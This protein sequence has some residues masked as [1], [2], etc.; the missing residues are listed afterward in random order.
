[1]KPWILGISGSHNGA[2]CL[3]RGN[4]I[5]VA[6]QEERLVGVKRARVHG[7]R[8]GLGIRYC[9]DT[10]GISA[11][12][13]SM[14]VIS[15]Q[16][17]ATAEENDLWL[18]PAFRGL[19]GVPRRSVSHHLA[20]AASAL[21]TSGYERA[22][23]LVIDGLGSPA[24]DLT[25]AARRV[26]LGPRDDG[27]EHLSL[28]HAT[29]NDITPIE[30]HTVAGARWVEKHPRGMWGFATL[31]GMFSAASQQIFGNP[32]DAGKVMGLAPYGEPAIPMDEILRLDGERLLFPNL[33]QRRFPF[34]ERWPAHEREYR[35]LAASVQAALEVAVLAIARRLREK[36]GER[37]LCYAGG[38]ALNSVVNERLCRETGF[39]RVYVIPAA[40]DSG[41][42]IGAAYLGLWEL[43]GA[44]PGV[45]MQ[46]DAP[47]RT[48][49]ASEIEAA[50]RATPD[51]AAERPADLLG[52]VVARLSRGEIGGWFQGGSELGPRALGQRSIVCSPAGESTKE[53]LNARVKFREMFRPFAPAVL[54]ERATEWF[55]FGSSPPE[56]PFMLRVV[57]FRADRRERVPAV[58]HVDGTG[59]VQTL[60]REHNGRFYELVE[61]FAS[62]T[63]IPILLNTSMNVR[64]EPIVETPEDALWCLLGTGLDFCVIH[65][66][67]VTK[68]ADYGG[69]LDYVPRVVADDYS[70]RM[71]IASGALQSS[72]RREDAITVRTTTPWGPAEIVLLHRLFP[73]LSAIDG[74]RDG[75]AIQQALAGSP[76]AADVV[77]DLLSLRRM[78]II[79]LA[80]VDT[81]VHAD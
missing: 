50:I 23:V 26:I 15:S 72:I 33:V 75:H 48:Y 55:D 44:S 73:L 8:R 80:K 22:A 70:L 54:A 65:D 24:G 12:D 30:V 45:Q 58:V 39:D 78:R 35:D 60:T 56:S 1:M 6:I 5:Q 49:P 63:G 76:S 9:L 14:I 29:R 21:A 25:D 13:L 37:A 32:M 66:W 16:G 7:A 3:L 62:A 2:Y 17:S 68:R 64:S 67:L 18:N 40:E 11:S 28:F 77:R 42:A 74:R 61:R 43:G 20:H 79:E 10:A 4:Q 47:G 52:E 69:V 36:T 59:R 34:Q 51:I 19:H 31:G 38:V 71:P 81:H 57:P 53:K 46:S 27:W 41:V